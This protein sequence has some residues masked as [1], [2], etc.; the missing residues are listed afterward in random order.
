MTAQASPSFNDPLSETRSRSP[1]ARAFRLLLTKKIACIAIAYILVFYAAGLFAPVVVTAL[2][3]PSPYEQQKAK[4]AT[5]QGPST[6]HWLGTDSLGRDMAARVIYSART[7]A[8]FT[9]VVMVT[10]GLFLG[11]GMGLLSG[12]RGGWVDTLIMRFGEVLS[13]LP[14]L[15]IMLALTA[16]FRT[17]INDLS[18]WVKDNTFLADDGPPIVQFML[19]ALVTVPFAWFGSSRIVRSQV[20]AIRES[21]YI[22][23]AELM[24]ARTGR[25]LFRHILPGVMPLFL[26]GLSSSMA[27]I[28]GAEVAL[29]F[30]GLGVHAPYASFGSM[31][32]DGAGPKT[33]QL[34]PHLLLSSAVP[35]IL[36]FFSWNLLGDAL[37]DVMQPRQ[38]TR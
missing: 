7:T 1:M 32:A 31:I 11:V 18:F 4:G 5:L 34:Y 24:G 2:G 8:I 3:M 28:A 17:R 19:I 14:T 37:V 35:V 12:Y 38:H 29:S 26:V 15:F 30:L 6:E 16:A 27:G 22:E 33:L 25:I 9:I 20:L 36:F 23:A 13:S 10:G 21:P